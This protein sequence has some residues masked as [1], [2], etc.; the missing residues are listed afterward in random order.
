MLGQRLEDAI[1]RLEI[2]G[3][4]SARLDVRLLAARALDWNGGQVLARLNYVPTSSQCR[5]LEEM[6]VRREGHEP[7]AYILGYAEFWSLD[8][9]VSADVLIPRPDSETLIESALAIKG[10]KAREMS[11]LDLG[12][13]SG[14]LLLAL[15]SELPNA[16]GLGV[17][18]SSL[19]IEV[20]KSNAQKLGLGGRISFKESDWDIGVDGLFNLIISNPPYI[21]RDDYYSL[22]RD[23]SGF[24]PRVALIG[25]SDGLA[26][27]RSLSLAII[28]KIAPGGCALIEIGADQAETVGLILNEA[29]LKVCAVHQDLAGRPRVLEAELKNK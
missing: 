25:G 8:F 19:A 26:C 13:G 10:I 3:I 11:I 1:K 12:T 4:Y 29:G 27:F 5:E 24:E 20:A 2:S 16:K 7:V 9:K 23:I 28:R 18:I 21:S 17:D 22:E 15:L 14:C 6:V